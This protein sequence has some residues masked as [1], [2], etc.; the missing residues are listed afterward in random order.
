VRR[1]AFSLIDTG[2]FRATPN[3]EESALPDSEKSAVV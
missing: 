2:T 1:R 3:I